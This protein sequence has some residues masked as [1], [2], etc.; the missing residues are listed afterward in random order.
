VI[1]AVLDTNVVLS[2]LIK[3]S[4]APGRVLDRLLGGA[5]T[6]VLSPDLVDELRRS[7]GYSRIRKYL[8]LSGEE[9]EARLAQLW[10]VADPVDGTLALEVELRDPQDRMVVVAAVEGRANYIVTGDKDLIVIGD[11]QGVSIVTPRAFLELLPG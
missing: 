9:L 1:R 2:A 11:Y 10:M 7:L 5:F 6:L 8:R 4:G 3:P